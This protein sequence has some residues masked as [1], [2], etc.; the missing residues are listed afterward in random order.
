MLLLCR[1]AL[2][3]DRSIAEVTQL[4]VSDDFEKEEGGGSKRTLTGCGGW[5]LLS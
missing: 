5:T 1:S 3:Q 2:K 4:K